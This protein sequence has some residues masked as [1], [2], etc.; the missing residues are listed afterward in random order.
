MSYKVRE[1]RGAVAVWFNFLLNYYQDRWFTCF[2]FR[3]RN[4]AI[5]YMPKTELAA[6]GAGHD[7]RTDHLRP[8]IEYLLAQ[9]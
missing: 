1:S 4:L 2:Y 3:L 5:P 7:P 9:G 8:V 6:Q